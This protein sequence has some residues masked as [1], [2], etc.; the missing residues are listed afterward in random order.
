MYPSSVEASAARYWS[1]RARL[2]LRDTAAA[3]GAWRVLLASD[4]TSYY[5]S[6]AARRLGTSPWAP[7]AAP[8]TF[9]SFPDVDATVSRA[10][11]LERLGMASEARL[12]LTAMAASADSSVERVLAIANVFRN[13]GQMRTAM[14]LGRRAVALGAEDARAW[15][16]VYPIGEADLVGSEAMDR[17]VDPALVAALIRQESS[18]DP[19]ATSPVGARGLMQVMPRVGKALARAEK[20]SPW[21][22]GM[23][24][25]PEVNV[26]LGVI[27]LGSFTRHYKHPAL[28]LAA[29]NAGGSRVARWSKRPGAM[30]PELFIERIRFTETRGYVRTVLRSRD[31]YAALYG[32]EPRTEAN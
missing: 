4:S 7:P 20:I 13:L 16:L 32:W 14:E 8:D 11:L 19:R 17:R 1:G 6:Q 15:R 27:H 28:A 31:M 26:R 25:D 21:D 10:A 2:A 30:D 12:E 23:L 29:Y 9:V 18:F 24:Y 22:P 3:H 5:A